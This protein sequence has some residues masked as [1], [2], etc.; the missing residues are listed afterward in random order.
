MSSTSR[1]SA[2][3]QLERNARIIADRARGH[4]WATIAKR[5]GVCSRQCM[6]IWAARGDDHYLVQTPRDEL[7][8]EIDFI[9]TAIADLAE[10]YDKTLNES[11]K[12][13]ALK[14]RLT[15]QERRVDMKKAAGLLPWDINAFRYQHALRG[16]I[17][18]L[19]DIV[20]EQEVSNEVID[21][22]LEV[23][24]TSQQTLV[25]PASVD[26]WRRGSPANEASAS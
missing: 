17:K 13:G 25:R 6:N 12:L 3:K 26:N 2:R 11:V 19:G 20:V 1:L 8:D 18:R 22:L 21:A 9:N 24:E 15:F 10:L 4:D 16:V 7:L 5:H 23:V 14:Q